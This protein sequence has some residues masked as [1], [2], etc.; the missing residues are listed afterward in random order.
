LKYLIVFASGSSSTAPEIEGA[1]FLSGKS[2]R[3]NW[4]LKAPA[5]RERMRAVLELFLLRAAMADAEEGMKESSRREVRYWVRL[6]EMSF[7]VW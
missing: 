4:G 1:N 3:A 6:E 2:I 7:S 5:Q